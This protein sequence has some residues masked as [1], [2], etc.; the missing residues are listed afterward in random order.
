[1]RMGKV[2]RQAALKTGRVG[3]MQG[4]GQAGF[5]ISKLEDRQA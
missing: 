3:D 4:W 5:G 1:M 2:K